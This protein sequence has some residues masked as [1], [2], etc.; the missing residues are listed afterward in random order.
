M[1]IQLLRLPATSHTTAGCMRPALRFS[2]ILQ[3]VPSLLICSN[4]WS[5]NNKSHQKY[6]YS[7][8]KIEPKKGR[9]EGGRKKEKERKKKRKSTS[10]W[11]CFHL[12]NIYNTLTHGLVEPNCMYATQLF[13][14]RAVPSRES[15][16]GSWFNCLLNSEHMHP[17]MAYSRV[18]H[19]EYPKILAG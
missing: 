5:R 2:L 7:Y 19:Q 9:E 1:A 13:Y 18:L 17:T 4:T 8:S 16:V 14:M 12:R 11:R 10:L 15:P 6:M 3:K